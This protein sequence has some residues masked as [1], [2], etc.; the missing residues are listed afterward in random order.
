MK[1]E[2]LVLILLRLIFY[3][4]N[5]KS[6]IVPR[7]LHDPVPI[8][9]VNTHKKYGTESYE[10]GATIKNGLYLKIS[11]TIIK[12]SFSEVY[13]IRLQNTVNKTEHVFLVS[14]TTLILKVL[15]QNRSWFSAF[16]MLIAT[17][18]LVIRFLQNYSVL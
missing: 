16:N 13:A 5:T 4:N 1:N 18:V 6:L 3:K 17:L 7:N 12:K 10:F 2:E 15:F 14:C 9:Q 8:F 11:L